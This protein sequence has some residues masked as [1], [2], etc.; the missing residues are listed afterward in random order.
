M[1]Q[2][3]ICRI[4]NLLE[5]PEWIPA[6]ANWLP[7]I[8][9]PH[10]ATPSYCNHL[11][12]QRTGHKIPCTLVAALDGEP[13]ASVFLNFGPAPHYGVWI[14]SLYVKP[15]HRRRGIGAAL[16]NHARLHAKILGHIKRL[17]LLTNTA[18]DFYCTRGWVKKEVVMIGTEPY[19]FLSLA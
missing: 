4:H 2:S 11:I 1:T 14:Q 13:V 18:T 10:I 3:A 16:L 7:Q 8:E 15:T 9:P 17:Y 19:D 6:V 5:K 12:Q